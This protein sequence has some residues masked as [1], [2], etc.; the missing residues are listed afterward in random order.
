M[1]L[2]KKALLAISNRLCPH[3][4]EIELKFVQ[5]ENA[6]SSMV[7][8]FDGKQTNLIFADSNA[9]FPILRSSELSGKT[10]EFNS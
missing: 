6:P 1:L 7:S 2:Y 5:F 8:I 10:I 9:Y 3:L 4:N